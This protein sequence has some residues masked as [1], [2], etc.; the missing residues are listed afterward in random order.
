M[1]NLANKFVWTDGRVG[2]KTDGKESNVAESYKGQ[3]VA[4]SWVYIT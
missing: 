3:E 2:I 4:E 1:S